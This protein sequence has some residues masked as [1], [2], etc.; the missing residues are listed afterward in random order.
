MA[1]V[2]KKRTARALSVKEATKE[3]GRILLKLT[4]YARKGDFDAALALY[5]L[6]SHGISSLKVVTVFHDVVYKVAK[7]QKAWPVLFSP[8][9]DSIEA[10]KE[11]VHRIGLG[12]ETGS[13][14]A[15]P[16]AASARDNPAIAVVETLHS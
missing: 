9:R 7:D 2:D 6:T 4:N 11:F 3:A 10:N 5:R 13:N 8:H 14:F 1:D 15:A 16:G 12:S